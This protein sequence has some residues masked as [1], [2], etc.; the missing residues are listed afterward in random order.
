MHND[1]IIVKS[2]GRLRILLWWLLFS[3]FIP[4]TNTFVS[5]NVKPKR[6]IR[7]FFCVVDAYSRALHNVFVINRVSLLQPQIILTTNV[8]LVKRSFVDSEGLCE[9]GGTTTQI[10][11]AQRLLA[12]ARLLS[13]FGD[14][15]D[16][17]FE[18]VESANEDCT[19]FSWSKNRF[20]L[21]GLKDLLRR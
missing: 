19:S 10:F 5:S 6:F 14:G 2:I 18:W 9:F 4:H 7:P 12:L 16:A 3:R 13:Q 20:K 8:F 15:G 1:K 21:F 17:A 11:Q